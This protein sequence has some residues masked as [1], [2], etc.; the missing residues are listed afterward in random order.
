MTLV[1]QC[2]N[3]K[4]SVIFQ[5]LEVI[6]ASAKITTKELKDIVEEQTIVQAPNME[7]VDCSIQVTKALNVNRVPN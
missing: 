4:L 6:N 2:N 1:V 3:F 5:C 7:Q